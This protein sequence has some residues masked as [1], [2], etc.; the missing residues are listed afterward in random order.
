MPPKGEKGE[1]RTQYTV[2]AKH[3]MVLTNILLVGSTLF[4]FVT[5]ECSFSG[6][7]RPGLLLICVVAS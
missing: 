5:F 7:F 1:K 3:G 4:S 2:A 6:E